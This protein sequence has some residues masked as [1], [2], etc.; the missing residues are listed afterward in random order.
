[1]KPTNQINSIILLF[2][3]LFLLLNTSC[4]ESPEKTYQRLEKT[5]N[6]YFNA[7]NYQKAL[8]TWQQMVPINPNASELHQKIG[9]CYH[10][11]GD[12]GNALQ[13]YHEVLRIQPENWN[14]RLYIA[15]IQLTLRDVESSE[16]SWEAIK[17][18]LDTPE[19]LIFHGDLLSIKNLRSE[20]EQ[21]Y[22]KALLREPANQTALIRLSLCLFAQGKTGEAE[23][24]FATLSASNPQ[25]ADILLQMS[26]YLALQGNDQQAELLLH[27]AIDLAPGDIALHIKLAN[28]FIESEKFAQAATALKNLLQISP[29]HRYAK[30]MLIDVMLLSN[31]DAEAKEILDSLSETEAKDVEFNFLKGKY[32]LKTLAYHAALSQFQM[33]LEKEPDFPL[34]YY[35]QAISYLAGGQ[36]NLG[37]KSLIKCLTL[38]PDFTEAEL[39]LADLYFKNGNYDFALE[40]A[41]R[42]RKREPANY[43][44]HL[45]SGNIHLAKNEYDKALASYSAVQRLHPELAAPLYYAAVNAFVSGN[46]AESLRLYQGILQKKPQ[47]IDTT[48]QYS[49]IL[50][51]SGKSEEAIRFLRHAISN[52][53]DNPYLH[54]ILG[55][56][57]LAASNKKEAG[58]SFRQALAKKPDLKSSYLQLFSLSNADEAELEQLLITAIS[59]IP[60]FEE[61]QIRLAKLYSNAG[62]PAKAIKLLEDAVSAYPK[63]PSLTNNL[64][65]L[66][67]EHQQEDIDEAMRLAQTAY[68]ILP[69]NPATADTLGWIYY[70]KKMPTRATWLL[71]QAHD[72]DQ[73]NPL[74][75]FHLGMALAE[76]GG[77]EKARKYLSRALALGID[78]QLRQD[79]EKALATLAIPK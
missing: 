25:S 40:H 11:L 49:R 73:D 55:E 60:N 54:H 20:A 70:I 21:E 45:I 31:R 71:E 47:L 56:T 46:P 19:A 66:Y 63:S 62:Q 59:H 65:W 78:A 16:T 18:H 14:A 10:L 13:A 30:K 28:F 15:K 74:I 24:T 69:G 42:I 22:R 61:A 75:N 4:S 26:N 67:V 37:E 8:E 5:G 23:K 12:Y 58:N 38:N 64:A 17:I 33:V 53:P 77:K 44:A 48:L 79:A 3:L 51:T 39:T 57:Y 7:H 9:D 1:M 6:D 34:A 52:E 72:L 32:F 35:F 2:T 43:R 36:S 27:K 68:E 29:D 76:G 41:E 50:A